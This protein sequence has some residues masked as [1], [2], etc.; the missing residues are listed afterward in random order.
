MSDAFSYD[1]V[2]Y[3]SLIH[4]QMHPSRLAAIARLHGIHAASPKACQL[5][6][7]GCGD[8]LQLLTLAMAYP[9]S[10]FIGVD[11]S[12]AAI[13]RGEAM[14]NRLGLHNLRLVAADLL[15][16]NPGPEPYDYIV[17]HGFYSWVPGIVRG[18]LLQLCGERLADTGIAYVS[19]NAMPGCHLRRMVWDMMR[20]HVRDITMPAERA[21]EARSFLEW[22]ATN[23]IGKPVYGDSLRLEAA[24]LLNRTNASVLYHDDLAEINAPFSISDFMDGASRSGLRFLAEADYSESRDEMLDDDVRAHLQA[25]SG[26]T[27]SRRSSTWIS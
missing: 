18:R 6:E 17:A 21:E 4:P 7:V 26:G 8:G 20:F 3:P 19:Y 1:V 12:A 9:Q 23:T 25:L 22:L 16:W 27:S 24:N 11:L 13:S 10:R 15:E 2:D 14:R 5:L